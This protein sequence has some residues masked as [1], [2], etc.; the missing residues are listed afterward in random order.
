LLILSRGEAKRDHVCLAE[1][2]GF[3]QLAGSV[4][5]ITKRLCHEGKIKAVD[6]VPGRV[7]REMVLLS[8]SLSRAELT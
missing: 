5:E 3:P 1:F 6:V 2:L 7:R 8:L 4:D